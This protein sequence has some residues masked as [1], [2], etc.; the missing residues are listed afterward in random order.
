MTQIEWTPY[1][2]NKPDEVYSCWV[3]H[4]L[5]NTISDAMYWPKND[6]FILIDQGKSIVLNVTHYIIQPS[7]PE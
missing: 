3:I 2:E 1:P 4:K 5:R 7:P 6:I